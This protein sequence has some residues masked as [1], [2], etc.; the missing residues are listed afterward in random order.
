MPPRQATPSSHRRLPILPAGW[1]LAGAAVAFT[2]MYVAAGAL[3]PLL[4]VYRQEW[5]FP[6]SELTL[7]FAV[8]AVGFLAGVLTLG[9]LSDHVGRRPVLLGALV[10]QLAS[11]VLLSLASGIDWVIAGR[12]VQG[13][14]TGV[15]T[16][17][18]TAVLVE[19]A[20]ADRKRLGATLGS[21][22]VTAGLALGSL[23]A[24]VAIQLTTSAN[25]ICFLV[26]SA[27]TVLGIVVV[28]LSPETALRVPG[29]LRSLRP[30]VVLPP[31]TREEFV[32]AAPVIAAV[33]MLAG[34]SGGL[35]PSMVGSVFHY[36]SGLLIGV[37]GSV[38]T[39]SS[40]I[41]GLALTPV[42]P[43]RAMTI[44]IYA[45]V[46]G[47][48][49]IIAG[50][51]AIS[52]PLM[53][54][55]QALAGAGFGASFTAALRLIFPRAAPNQRAG[56]DAA[57]YIVSYAAFGVPVVVAGAL[58]G[59]FGLATV[60]YGYAAI[61]VLLTLVSF[62]AQVRVRRNTGKAESPPCPRDLTPL[63]RS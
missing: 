28:V 38:S 42:D 21:V 50:V 56:V 54:I 37:A 51:H 46:A 16:S 2:T 3:T 14:A 31:A 5:Q 33:W 30:H 53:F 62:A 22:T 27:M 18:F 9:P 58:A 35:A 1:A 15:A 26:L 32:A 57:I 20:P 7:A 49:G 34:L 63:G 24:G 8:Y 59:P 55:G 43:R 25:A 29:A 41:V 10:L 12:V 61:A 40:A 48:L 13:L 52:L 4:V 36:D 44:G 6:A 39:A 17:A 19:V 11:N 45:S 23:L 47:A 60:V